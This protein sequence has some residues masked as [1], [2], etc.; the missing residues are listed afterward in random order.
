MNYPKA[1]VK[2][3]RTKRRAYTLGPEVFQVEEEYH[4]T[5]ITRKLFSVSV[6]VHERA[7]YSTRYRTRALSSHELL[8]RLGMSAIFGES[9]HTR[10][11]LVKEQI[12]LILHLRMDDG[13]ESGGVTYA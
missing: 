8:D 11:K 6:I 1:I 3:G 7:P 10:F 13:M 5:A 12:M 2:L 9:D 4:C